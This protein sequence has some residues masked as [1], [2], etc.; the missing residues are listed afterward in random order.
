MTS[1]ERLNPDIPLFARTGINLASAG[2]G[3]KAIFATNDFFA[4][5]ERMLHDSDPIFIEGKFDENGKWMDG[6]ES[7]RRRDGGHDHAIVRLAAPGRIIGFDVDTSHFTGNYAPAVMIEACSFKGNVPP[8]D[9]RW[10]PVLPHKPLGPSAHH[11]FSCSVY[12]SWTHLRV[13]IYPDGGVARLRVYGVPELSAANTDGD[14]D[15]AAALNGGR[16]LGFSDAHYGDYTRLLAPGRGVNMGDGWETR[17][18]REPGYDWMVIALGARGEIQ[19]AVVDTK[20]FKGNYPDSVSMQAADLRDFGD[21]L[22]D[23]LITDSMFWQ[24]ILDRQKL[25]PD[26]EH[27]FTDQL[28]KLGPVTHVRLNIHPDGGVSRLR[29]FGTTAP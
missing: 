9:Q 6:W 28:A 13:H 29:L 23:A 7:Q 5:L 15:L 21:G 24:R 14:I 20:F 12:E 18:R 16:I 10:V 17:R 2:L 25:G 1:I 22:T 3:A 26:A 19:R 27:H 11:Y 8:E 4:P